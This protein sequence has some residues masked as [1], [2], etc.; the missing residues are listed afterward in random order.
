[1]SRRRKKVWRFV[2][3]ILLVWLFLHM[4]YVTIDG[5]RS[6]DGSADMAV[7]L[8]NLVYSDGSLSPV[9][10]GR[11]DRALE[12]YQRGRVARIMVSGGMGEHGG[13]YPE[14]LAMKQYL[15]A[16]DV[17]SDRIF[18]DNHGENTYLTAKDFLPLADSL[19][20]HSVIVVSSFYHITRSKY[21][22]RKLGFRN[23]QGDASRVFYWNDLLGLPRDALAFYK[24]L[25]AY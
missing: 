16:R 7:V 13:H 23:V 8:G 15:V 20:V 22:F 21:I 11:V 1:M 12:L 2:I 9:L 18:E 19:H 4:L 24:Y 17:P 3:G 25:F 10:R 14:G 5:L 6:Y